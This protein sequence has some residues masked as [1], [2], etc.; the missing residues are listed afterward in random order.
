MSERL[1]YVAADARFLGE[2]R[3]VGAQLAANA[4]GRIV[5]FADAVYMNVR[6]QETLVDQAVDYDLSP[7]PPQGD[8]IIKTAQYLVG[9]GLARF[10]GGLRGSIDVTRGVFANVHKA[11]RDLDDWP[12]RQ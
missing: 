11:A 4:L 6:P 3:D 8:Q 10:L 1:P 2:L 7:V 9:K 12:I 5:E